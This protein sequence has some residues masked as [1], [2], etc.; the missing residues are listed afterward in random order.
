M[1]TLRRTLRELAVGGAQIVAV[2]RSA[3]VLRRWYHPCGA[4]EAEPTAAPT[5]DEIRLR[6]G[7]REGPPWR[8]GEPIDLLLER[9][10]PGGP[11]HRAERHATNAAY[12]AR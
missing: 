8:V 3:P 2:T 1:M 12:P 11:A 6:P 4:T 5:G 7:P 10:A 9:A